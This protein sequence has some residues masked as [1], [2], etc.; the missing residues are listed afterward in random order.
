ML[1]YI[2]FHKPYEVLSQFTDSSSRK[3]L[4]EYIDIP[5]VYAAGRLD[6]RSEGLLL[7][8]D[9]G[10]FIQRVTDP[11]YE[12]P[13]VYLAQVEGLPSEDEISHLRETIILPGLQTRLIEAHLVPDPGF[14]QR[15]RPVRPYHPT[16]WLRMVLREGKKHQVRRLTAALGYPTLRLVRTA[17]GPVKLGKL[18]PGDWRPLRREEITD[19]LNAASSGANGFG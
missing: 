18:Q 11:R 1:S 12:H 16:A 6:Y 15:A 7:L 5:G 4:K 9:D 3:T 2:A 17:I 10:R 8:S 13:K 14:A 19:L